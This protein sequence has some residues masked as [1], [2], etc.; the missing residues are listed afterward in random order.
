[1]ALAASAFCDGTPAHAQNSIQVALFPVA[2]SD[3]SV[4]E[5]ASAVAPALTTGLKRFPQ[6]Q[7]ATRPALDL[8]ATQLALGCDAASDEC[9]RAATAL[10]HT[11][12]LLA[13]SVERGSERQFVLTLLYFDALGTGSR[14]L[15]KRYPNTATDTQVASGIAPMLQQLFAG[16]PQPAQRP[17]GDEPQD[18]TSADARTPPDA[19]APELEPSALMEHSSTPV[20]PIVMTVVGA[21]ALS[22]GIVFGF[23][24]RASEKDYSAEPVQSATQANHAADKLASART[25]AMLSNLG[26]GIG[27]ALLAAGITLFILDNPTTR[28]DAASAKAATRSNAATI[29]AS[30]AVDVAPKSAAVTLRTRF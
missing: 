4:E 7:I 3:S 11:Q 29:I 23:L 25:Q 24:A 17:I 8:P 14:T 9:L 26:I 18:Q 21:A 5:V 1:V 30:V 12:A 13:A 28:I 27:G 20:V 10:A 22:T 15:T 6:V 2:A 19:P 16:L